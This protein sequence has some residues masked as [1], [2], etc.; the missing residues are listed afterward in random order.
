MP[1]RAKGS[2]FRLML[3]DPPRKPE[4]VVIRGDESVSRAG[5]YQ[6]IISNQYLS[7]CAVY[8]FGY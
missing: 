1:P 4:V 6:A 3:L 8:L 7:I 5:N 2:Q